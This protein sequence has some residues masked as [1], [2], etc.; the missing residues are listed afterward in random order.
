LHLD[1]SRLTRIRA[2]H[3]LERLA[4]EAV[5]FAARDDVDVEVRDALGDTDIDGDKRAVCVQPVLNG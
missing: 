4:K 2:A 1:D 5:A 3:P